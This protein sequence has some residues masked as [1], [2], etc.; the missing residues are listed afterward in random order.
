MSNYPLGANEDPRAPWHE[1]EVKMKVCEACNGVGCFNESD[2]CGAPIKF[3]D[4]CSD[5]GE[6]CGRAICDECDGTG[7]VPDPDEEPDPDM[8][9]DE[10]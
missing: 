10:I 5:C 2:C 3:S 4:V 7:K 1:T 9:R 6:H 8:Y